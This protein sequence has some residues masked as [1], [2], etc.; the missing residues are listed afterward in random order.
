MTEP[1]IKDETERLRIALRNAEADKA[2]L[3]AALKDGTGAER[4][5]LIAKHG[6]RDDHHDPRR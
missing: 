5:A 6:A 2:E 3:L 4:R 1:V